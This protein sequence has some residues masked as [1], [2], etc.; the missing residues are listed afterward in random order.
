MAY[1]KNTWGQ[2]EYDPE[3]TLDENKQLADQADALITLEKL[4]NIEDGIANIELQPGP[5]GEPGAD[6]TNGT[7]GADGEQ[8]PKG[9]PGKDGE[10]GPQ[11]EPG[12][13]GADGFPSE[14][15]WNALVS[16]VEALESEE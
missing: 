13:D 16:R 8:G 11:G 14:G 4:K 3:K 10:Q 6:G 15:D 5:Q 1:E 2:Y 7:D 12:Q 9:E